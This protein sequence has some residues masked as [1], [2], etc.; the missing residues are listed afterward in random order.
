M[1]AKL[2]K[3]KSDG[4]DV[5]EHISRKIRQQ[6]RHARLTRD[7]GIKCF[8]WPLYCPV[9]VNGCIKMY[10]LVRRLEDVEWVGVAHDWVCYR[11]LLNAVMSIH[12]CY[13][14]G[15]RFLGLSISKKKK[16]VPFHS[17]CWLSRKRVCPLTQ[18]WKALRGQITWPK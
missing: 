10:R 7:A 13:I 12:S 8:S 6:L 15:R 5:F 1:T 14:K 2:C 16:G 4:T 18:A 17:A 11:V 3:K 9:T